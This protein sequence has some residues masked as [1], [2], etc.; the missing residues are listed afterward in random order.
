VKYFEDSA[1]WPLL[2]FSANKNQFSFNIFKGNYMRRGPKI[3]AH[4]LPYCIPGNG[5]LY[6]K[7]ILEII[8]RK[9]TLL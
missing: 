5:F 9:N 6:E 4:S 7:I 3:E 2:D 1:K 8:F